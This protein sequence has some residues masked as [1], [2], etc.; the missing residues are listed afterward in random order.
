MKNELSSFTSKNNFLKL[1]PRVNGHR[2]SNSDTPAMSLEPP[3]MISDMA[4]TSGV[5]S[6][7][8]ESED[9]ISDL[10]LNR[11]DHRRASFGSFEEL[12]LSRRLASNEDLTVDELALQKR[13]IEYKT[14]LDEIVE[15]D[16]ELQ[17]MIDKHMA[18][19]QEVLDKF[20]LPKTLMEVEGSGAT[21]VDK[22]DNK[23][24]GDIDAV[25]GTG[26]YLQGIA[27]TFRKQISGFEDTITEI[28]RRA[29]EIEDSGKK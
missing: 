16:K 11:Y 8:Y 18:Q 5:L 28:E 6:S 4:N 12:Q 21:A 29:M 24:D 23:E 2:R 9:S 20:G 22:G 14:Q 17:G 10:P 15:T 1:S 25:P 7:E 3:L 13:M 26:D 27:T 19:L